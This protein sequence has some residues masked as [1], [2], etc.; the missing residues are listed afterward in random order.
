MI[1]ETGAIFLEAAHHWQGREGQRPRYVIVHGT[2]GFQTA[3]ACAQFFAE[4]STE[5]SAHYIVGRGINE[6]YQCVAEQDA[7]WANGAITGPAGQA[8]DGVH[9]DAFWDTGINPNLVS[10]AIEHIKPSKDNSDLLTPEQAATSFRLIKSICQRWAIPMRPADARGGI[11]GHFSI[12]PVNRSR[13]PGPYPWDDLWAYLKGSSMLTI[14][15]ASSYFVQLD[16]TIWRCKQNGFIVGHGILEF[17]RS[18]GGSAFFGLTHLGLPMSN[19]AE[20]TATPGLTLQRFERG[21]LMYDPGHLEDHPPGAGAVYLAHLDSGVGV[22][23]RLTQAL[24][25]IVALQQQIGQYQ[26]GVVMTDYANR[27]KQINALSHIP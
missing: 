20:V 15:A 6:L 23:P 4:E 17:Y 14:D 3:L 26:T 24:Q 7:P 9:H 18:F 25:Q 5:A 11:T 21:V 1:G 19:E 13:C 10:I 22:D 27:L 12:D 2:A 16:P 8:G